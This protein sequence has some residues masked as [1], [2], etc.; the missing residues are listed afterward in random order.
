[1]Y[2]PRDQRRVRS[3]ETR[4]FCSGT[5]CP[6]ERTANGEILMASRSKILVRSILCV[7][8][9]SGFG[10]M[11]IGESVS[12]AGVTLEDFEGS[13]NPEG[14]YP[15]DW[16]VI[17]ERI[18]L[19]DTSLAGCTSYDGASYS[20]LESILDHG[21]LFGPQ[22][23]SVPYFGTLGTVL[24]A[25]YPYYKEWFAPGEST[26]YVLDGLPVWWDF[27]RGGYGFGPSSSYP[28]EFWG[29]SSSQRE[30]ILD[31][32]AEY[33][34]DVPEDPVRP[35]Y[36]DRF[37]V[38]IM[39]G[40]GY[41]IGWDSQVLQMYLWT[42]S[43]QGHVIHGPAVVSSD[44]LTITGEATLRFWFSASRDMDNFHVSGYLQ[45]VGDCSTRVPLFNDTGR[46][47]DWQEIVRSDIPAGE[48]RFVFVG[49]T[50]DET[51]GGIGGAMLW[52]DDISCEGEGGGSSCTV[53]QCVSDCGDVEGT[54][55]DEFERLPSENNTGNGPGWLQD[56][57]ARP[58]V[59][60]LPNTG[61][62]STLALTGLALVAVGFG[63]RIAR[64]VRAGV[65]ID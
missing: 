38:T 28:D 25:E 50:Y 5:N 45:K 20:D 47:L 65:R 30:E 17:Q 3:T 23:W 18:V 51:W 10:L 36:E 13:G 59:A 37:D 33:L 46:S 31:L 21:D 19:G 42:D 58:E 7:S 52:V 44:T 1:M 48:Y 40:T 16:E 2:G 41:G 56:A 32:Q 27:N 55:V 57:L 53:T 49:G 4:M 43:Y 60:S 62:N 15:D 12:A 54:G 29:L 39:D 63:L 26:Q 8:V 64:R 11:P 24:H 35:W 14:G 34:R 61:T 9:A 22:D 6:P